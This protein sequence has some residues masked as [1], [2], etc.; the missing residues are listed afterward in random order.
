MKTDTLTDKVRYVLNL[1]PDLHGSDLVVA[2]WQQF[3]WSRFEITDEGF[4]PRL[5]SVDRAAQL[6]GP[7]RIIAAWKR[8]NRPPPAPP[9]SSRPR[10][11]YADP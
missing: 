5:L 9:P 8:L 6:P 4:P 2:V 1:H 3:Y 11:P 7:E 10:F